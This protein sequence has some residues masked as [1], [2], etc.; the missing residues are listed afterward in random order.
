MT[1]VGKTRVDL[2]GDNDQIMLSDNLA[3]PSNLVWRDHGPS[4]ITRVDEDQDLRARR[5]VLS[6]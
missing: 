3:D 2:I 5:N 1:I 4:R 6:N